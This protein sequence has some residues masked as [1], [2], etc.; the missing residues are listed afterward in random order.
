MYLRL[1][2]EENELARQ[3]RLLNPLVVDDQPPALLHERRSASSP[4]GEGLSSP[5]SDVPS[6][7]PPLGKK[8]GKDTKGK[9]S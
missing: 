4:D 8:S 7:A 5:P 9:D 6:D 2:E 3:S 1:A